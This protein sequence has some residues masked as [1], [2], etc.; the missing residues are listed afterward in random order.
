MIEEVK[1]SHL[2]ALDVMKADW[3]IATAAPALK[4][5]KPLVHVRGSSEVLCCFHQNPRKYVHV[6]SLELTYGHCVIALTSW[7]E[8]VNIWTY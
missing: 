5:V 1:L 2:L 3:V 6:S 4:H 8:I 7:E